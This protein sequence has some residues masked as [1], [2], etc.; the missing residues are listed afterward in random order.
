MRARRTAAAGLVAGA[1]ALS[2]VAAETS[3]ATTG[4]GTASTQLLGAVA[5]VTGPVSTPAVNLLDVESF[6]TTADTPS[7]LTEVVPISVGDEAVGRA[8]ASSSADGSASTERAS[9]GDVAGPLALTVE[10]IQTTASATAD[11]ALATVETATADLS[12]LFGALGL[13]LTSSGVSSL[14][15]RDAAGATQGL[16]VSGLSLDLA[17]LGLGADVLGQLGLA[18]VLELLGA[19]PGLLPADLEGAPDVLA[20]VDELDGALGD[21][22]GEAQQLLGT[23]QGLRS[24]AQD[25]TGELAELQSVLASLDDLN[26]SDPTA[27]LSGLTGLEGALGDVACPIELPDLDLSPGGLLD[28]LLGDPLGELTG[29]LDGAVGCVEGLVGDVEAQLQAVLGSLP[30]AGALT[31]VLG[32]LDTVTGQVDEILA[33]LGGLDGL[34]EQL[35]GLLDQAAASDLL[36]F[37]AFDIGT[38]AKAGPTVG[39]STATVLCSGTEVTVLGRAFPT[40][41]CSEGL[42]ALSG[43][44][45]NVTGALGGVTDILDALPLLEKT[46]ELRLDMFTDVVEQVTE[47]DGVVTAVA[48]FNLL[49]LEVPSLRLD[50]ELVEGLPLGDLELPVDLAGTVEG[51]LGQ[52]DTVLGQ[53]GGLGFAVDGLTGPVEDALGGIGVDGGLTDLV[54]QVGDVLDGLPLGDLGTLT[55]SI[56]TPGLELLIDPV[57]TASFSATAAPAPAPAPSPTPA[58]APAPDTD[59]TPSLPSTGGGLALLGVLAMAGAAGL[60]RRP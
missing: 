53:L 59:P 32:A 46:G 17:D 34:L 11:R 58:P 8:G 10:P 55:E 28:D 30:G 47:Q 2:L 39:D 52:L 15:T 9:Y 13:D 24:Q 12:A 7:A 27:L 40:P 42:G 50:P 43:L 4:A 23:L 21:L 6:A 57:S 37:G 20:A 48:G 56:A 25:L 18:D 41:D 45:G 22:Q 31:P 44:S 54:G 60:R 19:L 16:Q 51:L 14:A 26:T 3:P 29:V 36:G 1:L 49:E 5:R 35:P 38:T 33:M